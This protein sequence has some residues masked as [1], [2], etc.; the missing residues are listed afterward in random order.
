[1]SEPLV[2]VLKRVWTISSRSKPCSSTMQVS[3][4]D[5]RSCTLS[6]VGE[7]A[8]QP[9]ERAFELARARGRSRTARASPALGPRFSRKRLSPRSIHSSPGLS[10]ASIWRPTASGIGG[11]ALRERRAGARTQAGSRDGERALPS[12]LRMAFSS[13][14][15]MSRIELRRL[16][17]RRD[18]DAATVASSVRLSPLLSIQVT[19]IL[20]PAL[21]PLHAQ[22]RGTGLRDTAW[23]HW[24]VE[25][26]S[27]R[28]A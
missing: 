21:A 27:C 25:H 11:L 10:S 18:H 12:R 22:R 9:R 3:S 8:R 28:C 24:R 16:S 1:M 19:L 23:L 17:T 4:R 5:S 26:R 20:S 2:A 7:V 15:V 14:M 13:V 6:G